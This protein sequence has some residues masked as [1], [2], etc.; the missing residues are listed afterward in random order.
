MRLSNLGPLAMIANC[1]KVMILV[2]LSYFY[3][4]IYLW[5]LWVFVDECGLFYSFVKGRLLS[6]FGGQAPRC[7]GFRA[8]G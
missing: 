2:F 8:L 7:S 6:S 4:F 3:L 1:G 5:L